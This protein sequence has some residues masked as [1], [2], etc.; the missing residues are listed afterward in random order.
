MYVNGHTVA[1]AVRTR[2]PAARALRGAGCTRL[3]HHAYQPHI[4][5]ASAWGRTRSAAQNTT[6]TDNACAHLRLNAAVTDENRGHGPPPAAKVAAEQQSVNCAILRLQRDAVKHTT[7]ATTFKSHAVNIRPGR[8]TYD[9]R[10]PGRYL[11][12]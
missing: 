8:G 6:S 11:H 2:A 4:K 10:L 3:R 5:T 9:R 12:N 1:Q 7:Q